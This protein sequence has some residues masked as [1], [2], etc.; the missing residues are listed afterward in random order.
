MLQSFTVPFVDVEFVECLSLCNFN[1]S[2]DI[3]LVNG[4]SPWWFGVNINTTYNSTLQV[5]LC[6]PSNIANATFTSTNLTEPGNFTQ[7]NTSL[8]CEPLTVEVCVHILLKVDL[9]H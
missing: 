5:E 6:L 3:T 1:Q 7:S 4:S 8:D 2:M 9:I